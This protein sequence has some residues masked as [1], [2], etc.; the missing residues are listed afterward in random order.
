M[1]GECEFLQDNSLDR[2]IDSDDAEY[3][4]RRIRE[5]FITGSSATIVL[6]GLETFQRKWVDWEIYATL[7]K[8]SALIGVQLPGVNPPPNSGF[9]V[10]TRLYE[11]IQTGYALWHQ[12]NELSMA[13]L[14]LWIE[15]GIS[16]AKWSIKNGLEKK[17]QNG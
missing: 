5:N 2:R 4:E 1:C 3:Q 14:R 17:K 7:Y 8:E 9:L 6:C 10:P 12:W 15:Q 16:R 13:N 11:N